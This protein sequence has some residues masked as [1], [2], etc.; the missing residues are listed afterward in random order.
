MKVAAP[1]PLPKLRSHTFLW[2][3]Y[4]AAAL[5]ALCYIAIRAHTIGITY[6]E[7]WTLHFYVPDTMMHII[8]YD[9]PEANNHILNTLLVKGLLRISDTTFAA[10]LPNVLA[11]VPYAFFGYKIASRWLSFAIGLAAFLLL[12]LNPFLLDFFG[13]ARGYGLSL[14]FVMASLY[15]LLAYIAE[16]KTAAGVWAL[17]LGA[18]AVLA[19]FSALHYWLAAFCAVLGAA[20]FLPRLRRWQTIAYSL[21]TALLLAAILYE[22]ARKLLQA[23]KLSYGGET[24]FYSDTLLSLAHYSAYRHTPDAAIRGALNAFLILLAIAAG[25]SFLFRHKL[26]AP[27]TVVVALTAGAVLSVVLQHWLLG[28]LYLLDRT[29][30]FFYPLAVW[31]L[32]FALDDIALRAK[33]TLRVKSLSLAIAWIC[34]AAAGVNFG[35]HANFY[36]TAIWDFDAH[37]REILSRINAAGKARGRSLTL[38]YPWPFQCSVSYYTE[39][40]QYPFVT[41]ARGAGAAAD[42]SLFLSRPLDRAPWSKADA[43]G[44]KWA[45]DTAW[46]YPEEHIV[47]YRKR[48]VHQD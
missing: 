10:R 12:L 22:P 33:N 2:P 35:K 6:D 32:C 29:A 11:F 46:S 39:R 20:I 42:Y 17:A 43:A 44:I 31:C 24:G 13:L 48:P 9:V 15:C 30:L 27:K 34:V 4:L 19:N 26:T 5:I 1:L 8:N 36:K 23:G 37:T 7:E 47:V 41:L 25:A 28:T 40:Q 16:R 21:L 45:A 38:D 18:L 3:A 14:G